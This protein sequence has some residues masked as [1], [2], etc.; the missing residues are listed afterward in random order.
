MEQTRITRARSGSDHGPHT[1]GDPSLENLP[2]TVVPFELLGRI[3]GYFNAE[4]EAT[5]TSMLDNPGAFSI[6]SLTRVC[7]RWRHAA[8]NHRALWTRLH[9]D[10]TRMRVGRHLAFQTY[11][12]TVLERSRNATLTVYLKVPAKLTAAEHA[13]ADDICTRALPYTAKI[14]VDIGP[15]PQRSG[16]ASYTLGR[17]NRLELLCQDTPLL[18]IGPTLQRSGAASYMLGR[19]HSLELLCQDTPL[20]RECVVWCDVSVTCRMLCL[21]AAPLLQVLAV[22]R[23][24]ADFFAPATHMNLRYLDIDVHGLA[25]NY[26]TNLS[27]CSALRT[28]SLSCD[29]KGAGE[30]VDA[31]VPASFPSLETLTCGFDP[32]MLRGFDFPKLNTL[33]LHHFPITVVMLVSTLPSLNAPNIR[34]LELG[35]GIFTIGVVELFAML[36]N[37]DTLKLAL[38]SASED[39]EFEH[40]VLFKEWAE[41][42]NVGSMLPSL[43]TLHIVHH[44]S[45]PAL[46]G[47]QNLIL[48]LKTRI[49][50]HIP[51]MPELSLERFRLPAESESELT[52]LVE[53]LHILPAPGMHIALLV[54]ALST[55]QSPVAITC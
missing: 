9:L 35:P 49:V 40:E 4:A 25:G 37:L 5:P 53:R 17:Y 48:L 50:K 20:L 22:N 39:D 46:C 12:N 13:I 24:A 34:S 31:R 47:F 33:V 21:P 16:A 7:K 38:R 18:D 29:F 28:L 55:T 23:C 10:M 36:S 27:K 45:T 11:A 2:V 44:D 43:K 14:L 1:T 54:L 41:R 26:L 52:A 6:F 42:A 32:S 30:N 51:A 15:T 3:F 19:Y 8:I